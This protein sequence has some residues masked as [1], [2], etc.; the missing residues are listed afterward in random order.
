MK[1]TQLGR[2]TRLP[3]VSAWEGVTRPKLSSLGH[4][5]QRA[6]GLG[7]VP[8]KHLQ[9]GT[10]QGR[11]AA[12]GSGDPPRPARVV[13]SAEEAGPPTRPCAGVWTQGPAGQLPAGLH[14]PC[15][16]LLI[17]T[18]HFQEGRWWPGVQDQAS[19]LLWTGFGPRPKSFR[20]P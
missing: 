9:G 7:L 12:A 20:V 3:E 15:G 14:T 1:R 18:G 10:G 17:K 4:R 8:K 6:Q 16:G 2:R 19:S 11:R 13:W 5:G